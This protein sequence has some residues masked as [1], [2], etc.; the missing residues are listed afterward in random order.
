MKKIDDTNK[1]ILRILQGNGSI[2]NSD[3]SSR[4]GLAPATTLERVKKLENA[5]IINKYVALVNPEKVGKPIIAFVELYMKE[6]SGRTIKQFAE[7]ISNI[8][9]VL[10]CYH[11]SGSQDFL[12]KV[13]T[14]DI[15]S[16]ESFALEKLSEI[17]NIGRVNTM[18]VL[19]TVKSDTDI[20]ID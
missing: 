15:K 8:P 3:L 13:I 20:P 19:S 14:S 18:F 1:K 5:G 7:D 9:E 11:I 2:T 6:H 16:Y 10:E 4:V 12:L 17:P